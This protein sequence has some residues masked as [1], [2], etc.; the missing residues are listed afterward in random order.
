MQNLGITLNKNAKIYTYTH[1]SM[2]A[3]TFNGNWQS[4]KGTAT[5]LRKINNFD[6]IRD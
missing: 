2:K 6:K 3:V 4:L 5:P 1:L